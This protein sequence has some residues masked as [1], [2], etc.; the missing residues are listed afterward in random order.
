MMS[1]WSWARRKAWFEKNPDKY[2]K[3]RARIMRWRA[4]NPERCREINRASYQ[5]NKAYYKAYGI[6]YRQDNKE[7]LKVALSLAIPIAEARKLIGEADARHRSTKESR[8]TDRASSQD[9]VRNPT[10]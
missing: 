3:A 2:V 6:K 4:R 7:A 9:G 8:R 1:N 5:R 10:P